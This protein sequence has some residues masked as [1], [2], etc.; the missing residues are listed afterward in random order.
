MAAIEQA[1]VFHVADDR[2]NAV[3]PLLVA[4]VGGAVAFLLAGNVNVGQRRALAAAEAPVNQG[5]YPQCLC[6]RSRP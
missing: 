3:A 1:F 6:T 4:R 5:V 2:L